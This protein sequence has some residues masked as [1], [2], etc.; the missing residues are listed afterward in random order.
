MKKQLTILYP[1]AFCL[2]ISAVNSQTASITEVPV[3]LP[4]YPYS[5]PD[6][7]PHPGRI[8]PYFR[9]DEYS[10]ESITREWNMVKLENDFIEVYITPE[11]GGK[12][13]GA[14]EK[15]SGRQFVYFNHSVK[16]RDIAMRGPW[17]SGG[18]EINFGVIGHAPTCSTPVDYYLRKFDD[19]SVSCFIG[20]IDLSSRTEWRIEIN[21]HPDRSYFTTHALWINSTSQEQSYYH[22]MNGSVKADGNL[23]F[24]YPGNAYIGHNGIPASWPEDA[25]G[26]NLSFYEKNNFGSYKSYHVLGEYTNFFGGYWH[27]D[28]FGFGRYANYDDKPGKK[29]WI[30]G[31]S[32]QGMI[33]EDLLTDSDGQYIEIQS[34]R[35]FNQES[36]SSTYT[37]FKHR[38]FPPYSADIWTEHW[39]PVKNTNGVDRAIPEASVNIE[40]IEDSLHIWVCSNTYLGDTITLLYEPDTI[41]K[42]FETLEPTETAH[43]S[44]PFKGDPE[45]VS[46]KIGQQYVMGPGGIAGQT[47]S[48]PLE[49]PEFDWNSL[50]GLYLLGK[51][52]FRQRSWSEAGT[53]FQECLKKDP[54]YLPALTGFAQVK[55]K[56]LAFQKAWEWARKALSI[57]TYDPEANFYYGI[58]S[59]KTGRIADAKD[60]FSIAAASAAYRCGSYNELA[61]IYFREG[62][63]GKSLEYS[64]KSMLYN[65][66]N[67]PG[68]EL[69]ALIYRKMGMNDQATA[70]LV[71]LLNIDPLNHFGRF[72]KFLPEGIERAQ[73]ELAR[74]IRNE[75][76]QET[77]LETALKY[78]N[79]DCYRE[80][81]W[82]LERAPEHPMVLYWLAYMNSLSGKPIA[83]N[84]LFEKANQLP[85]YLVFPFREESVE[86]LKW[87]IG[88]SGSWKPKYYLS[89][90]YW[91]SDQTGMARSLIEACGDEPDYP[92]FSLAKGDL[93]SKEDFTTA[94]KSYLKALELDPDSW[95]AGYRT[96]GF[97]ITNNMLDE[98]VKIS[99]EYFQKFPENYYLGLQ[100]ANL[101]NRKGQ[102]ESSINVLKNLIVLPNEGATSGRLIWHES[103]LRKAVQSM[104]RH[105]FQTAHNHI[106]LA[107]EWPENLGVGKP[108]DVDERLENFLMVVIHKY[109]GREDELLAVQ[110]K[111]LDFPLSKTLSAEDFITAWTLKMK[112]RKTE[113]DH[114]MD[115]FKNLPESRALLWCLAIY[116]GEFKR[117]DEI[118]EKSKYDSH[119]GKELTLDLLIKLNKNSDFFH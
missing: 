1:L 42:Q 98:A 81:I 48:R 110:Q 29:I 77:F 43:Y 46:L 30:W 116:N 33:W 87:A 17:T 47:L 94:Q 9:F 99:K 25:E 79:L 111:I 106:D 6:P 2:F 92:V 54:N 53:L 65:R 10:A 67:L 113:A 70:V 86:M 76:P 109:A 88:T 32:R 14:I 11:I 41:F 27:D 56:H 102:Y 51:E 31:L 95:R 28:H 108:Y 37:P 40:I 101:L 44:F 117:A 105:D 93:Y 21:L 118:L 18:I 24:T 85:P 78:F 12:I 89:L 82:I 112:N 57:D 100:Y 49:K 115:K 71:D 5:S 50:Y 34:G 16:F 103:N 96:A 55:L 23:E 52:K 15:S 62:D 64:K 8:Y 75:F 90:I 63:M 84:Q 20:V 91:N 104:I 114:I 39:F 4:T 119:I 7:V 59:L 26:R 68:L 13:W 69:M 19:G 38:G 61:K 107:L 72:E 66:L 97:Y 74:L 83:A 80:A 73:D 3:S 35:L 58:A 36:T 45:Q 22:W 60:G